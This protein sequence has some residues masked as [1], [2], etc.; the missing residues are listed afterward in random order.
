MTQ[1]KASLMIG[2]SG[3]HFHMTTLIRTITRHGEG[4]KLIA[5]KKN[6]LVIFITVYQNSLTKLNLLNMRRLGQIRTL[7]RKAYWQDVIARL[8]PMKG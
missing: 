7:L 8:N 2:K 4:T 3:C 6:V 1:V 5:R